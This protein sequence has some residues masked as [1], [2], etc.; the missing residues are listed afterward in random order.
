MAET[1]T[2]TCPECRATI[3]RTDASGNE[4]GHKSTCSLG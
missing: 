1:G 4:S 2:F 3:R